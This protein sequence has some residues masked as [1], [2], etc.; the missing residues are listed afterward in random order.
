MSGFLGEAV[1]FGDLILLF[2]GAATYKLAAALVGG[3]RDARQERR[4]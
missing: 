1:T 4:S 2:V 3:F